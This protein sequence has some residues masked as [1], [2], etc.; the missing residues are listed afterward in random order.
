VL[1]IDDEPETAEMIA[2]M[3]RLTGNDVILSNG[4]TTAITQIAKE[5]PDIIILDVM[6]PELSGL[7]ILGYIRRDPRL[8]HI[9]VIV[10]SALSR[11]EDIQRGMQAGAESYL[12][13]PVAYRDLKAA[14][15]KFIA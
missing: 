9:P 6:M 7:D 11:P 14:V 5:N 4:G 2:E 10:V 15:Q 8:E 12:T 3:I 13:K 1:V